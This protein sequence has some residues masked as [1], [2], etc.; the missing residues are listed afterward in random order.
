MTV[1]IY[2]T[3]CRGIHPPPIC[4]AFFLF[5]ESLCLSCGWSV[6]RRLHCLVSLHQFVLIVCISLLCTTRCLYFLQDASQPFFVCYAHSHLC[7]FAQ[8]FDLCLEP[9]FPPWRGILLLTLQ[10]CSCALLVTPAGRKKSSSCVDLKCEHTF[11]Y[12]T[13]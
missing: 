6:N 12:G 10:V 8:L 1:C 11:F 9:S 7:D 3:V 4:N 2:H 13:Y 5:A